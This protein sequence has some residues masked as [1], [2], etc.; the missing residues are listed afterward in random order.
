[1]V[2]AG[3]LYGA[4]EDAL[5]KYYQSAWLQKPAALPIPGDGSNQVPAIH[6]KDLTS[7]VLKIA[8]TPPDQKYHFAFDG[9][10]DRSLKKIIHDISVSA[11]SGQTELVAQTEL[12]K[13]QFDPLM[14]I[15]FW[16]LPSD[17]LIAVP[18]QWTPE[19]IEKMGQ[20]KP[21]PVQPA[22]GSD[23]PADPQPDEPPPE[24]QD[25]DFEWTSKAGIGENG[26]L[27]L[28]EFCKVH[29]SLASCRPATPQ[30]I[31]PRGRG[32]QERPVLHF[33]LRPLLHPRHQAAR[34]L[35]ARGAP[36]HRRSAARGLQR[37]GGEHQGHPRTRH[38]RRPPSPRICPST[39]LPRSSTDASSTGWPRTTASTEAT[40]STIR[41]WEKKTST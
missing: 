1:M 2:C 8:D 3:L 33:A 12:V 9:S 4:G 27:I 40:S 36:L 34:S 32:R 14:K 22:D 18:F 15:D 20:P 23:A 26:K 5:E 29:S 19:E 30:H 17:L 39:K 6:V 11:G 16:A 38:L 31:R 35:R 13:E 28:A 41:S 24:P 10:K 21:D 25:P 37:R 7:F